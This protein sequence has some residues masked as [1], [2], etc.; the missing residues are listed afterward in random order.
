MIRPTRGRGQ[1]PGI[2]AI[3]QHIPQR[4]QN[5]GQAA[6]RHPYVRQRRALG[7]ASLPPKTDLYGVLDLIGKSFAVCNDRK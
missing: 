7:T 1:A 4:A 6:C 2:V 5:G 3:L